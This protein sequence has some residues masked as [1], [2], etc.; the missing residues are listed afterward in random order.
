MNFSFIYVFIMHRVGVA[1][2]PG[3]DGR[4][5]KLKIK[6]KF[7]HFAFYGTIN[8]NFTWWII[9]FNIVYAAGPPGEAGVAGPPGPPGEV[10]PAGPA[11][12]DGPPGPKVS[13][14]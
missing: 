13:A 12:I 2:I 10:G 7:I 8:S 3:H 6:I 9:L 14:K 11:G 5:G 4:P 1:G